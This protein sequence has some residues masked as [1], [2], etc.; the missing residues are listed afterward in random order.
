MTNLTGKTAIVTG[1]SRGIGR[2]SALALAK[3]GAHVIV[4][5][6]RGAKE[7]AAVVA[8]IRQPAGTLMQSPSTWQPRMVHT[9]SP[10]TCTKSSAAGSTF[11]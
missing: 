7:A 10:V 9:S 3:T 2:A 8:E 4:H 1:A 11:S 5:Y 6:G